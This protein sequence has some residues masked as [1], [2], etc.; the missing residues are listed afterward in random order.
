MRANPKTQ[1]TRRRWELRT[2]LHSGVGVFICSHDCAHGV[3]LLAPCSEC[4]AE[5]A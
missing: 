4:E 2:K 3:D 5:H 1:E